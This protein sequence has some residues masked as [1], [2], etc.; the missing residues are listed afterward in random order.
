M[1]R[2][3]SDALA[4]VRN[5]SALLCWGEKSYNM[6]WKN[7]GDRCL[8]QN[9]W[10]WLKLEHKSHS[11]KIP[12]TCAVT[13]PVFRF[14]SAVCSWVCC[15]VLRNCS[16][17]SADVVFMCC[18]CCCCCCAFC[19]FRGSANTLWYPLQ[20]LDALCYAD[21]GGFLGTAPLG[22]GLSGNPLKW[23]DVCAC[24]C[25]CAAEYV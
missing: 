21:G 16:G 14:L 20:H 19:H 12:S 18:C 13:A 6:Q 5:P 17:V 15:G 3:V 2:E 8:F 10:T 11:I 1:P 9:A 4:E 23:N 24:M 7:G 25:A 22:L